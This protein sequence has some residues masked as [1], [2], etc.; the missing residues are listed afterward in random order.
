MYDHCAFSSIFSFPWSKFI[1]IL[2]NALKKENPL[3]DSTNASFF[4]EQRRTNSNSP[5]TE[6]PSTPVVP[7][8][9]NNQV[10]RFRLHIW[11]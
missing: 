5:S 2:Q 6:C 7:T 9:V 3:S 1:L 10:T 4:A 8:F 11:V